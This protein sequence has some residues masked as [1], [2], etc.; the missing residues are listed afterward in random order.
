VS[1]GDPSDHVVRNRAAWD[2]LSVEFAEP[3]RRAWAEPEPT[4]GMWEIPE[5]EIRALPDVAGKDAIE[6]GCGT[7]YWSA[8]LARRGARVVGLDN[9]PKQLATARTLQREHGLAFPLIHA[10]AERV[11]LADASFDLAL[12]EYGASIWCDPHRWIPE[13]ARLLRPGGRLVF[14][15]TGTLLSLCVPDGEGAAGD[16]LLRSYFGLNRLEWSDDTTVEWSLPF[17][18]WIRLFRASGLELVDLI[19]L[20]APPGATS[21]HTY[22]TG[23]W[24]HRWPSEEIWSLRKAAQATQ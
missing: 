8:W 16:R 12:S 21:R 11:P 4:W 22:V 7:A 3:G 9:S 6:L 1:E 13:A 18:E 23:E 5:R 14:L 10:D 24:A 17:G 15:K 19:E 20:R 2:R